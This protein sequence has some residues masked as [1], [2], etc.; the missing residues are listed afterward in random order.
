M[1]KSVPIKVAKKKLIG[2]TSDALSQLSLMKKQSGRN[3]TQI[4]NDLLTG[5]SRFL[6]AIETLIQDYAA[7]HDMSRNDAIQSLLLEAV[8]MKRDKS[9][10]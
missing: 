1:P 6:P 4:I 7:R 2:F 10:E 3:Q 9:R 8:A 5:K